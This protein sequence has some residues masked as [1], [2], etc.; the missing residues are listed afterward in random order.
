MKAGL[1]VQVLA[2]QTISSI[3]FLIGGRH[4]AH[5]RFFLGVGVT[6]SIHGLLNE[7]LRPVVR[8]D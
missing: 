3:G 2:H 1:Q 7:F 4:F 6:P 5:T 8:A